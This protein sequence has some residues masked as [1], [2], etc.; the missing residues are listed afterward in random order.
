MTKNE[1]I[2]ELAGLTKELAKRMDRMADAL[3]DL[4]THIRLLTEEEIATDG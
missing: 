2:E 3:A 1:D 4:S